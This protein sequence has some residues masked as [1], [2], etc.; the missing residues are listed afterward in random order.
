MEKK[1]TK[2]QLKNPLTCYYTGG[3]KEQPQPSPGIQ[4]KMCTL[5]AC[6]VTAAHMLN[7]GA[8]IRRIF[9]K[10]GNCRD[11]YKRQLYMRGMGLRRTSGMAVKRQ[12]YACSLYVQAIS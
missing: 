9:C 6:I 12:K 1:N 7:F 5:P 11:V 3:Y 10:E 2:E 8:G 4:Q